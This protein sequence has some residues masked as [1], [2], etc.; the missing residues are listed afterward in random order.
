MSFHIGS[1]TKTFTAT[2]ILMLVDRGM[3]KLDT[4]VDTI[5]PGALPNGDKITVRHLL[6][7]RSG[8]SDYPAAEIFKQTI[9]R[10]PLHVWTFPELA[11]LVQV[12]DEP[13]ETFAYR[14]INFVTLGAI[15]E[16]LTGRSRADFVAHE[17]CEPLGL[18]HTFVPAD[19]KMPVNS[20][21]GYLPPDT[22]GEL[23][24]DAGESV[25]PSWGGAAGDM[26]STAADLV[27]WLKALSEGTLLSAERRQDMFAM[28]GDFLHGR[29]GGYGQGVLMFSGAVGHGGDYSGIYTS[30]LFEYQNHYMAVL[31]N[32]QKQEDGGDATALFLNWPSAFI[33]LP[34]TRHGVL[35][36]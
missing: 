16:K 4:T 13:D 25:D 11:R 1:V 19:Q 2:A 20:A 7:M 12:E 33:R 3:L 34:K 30:A 31:V 21:H 17:I 6:M 24:E 18:T 15:L 32:G 36:N 26:I 27:K 5:L 9:E 14:N 35:D 23:P 28:R 8:L 10:N 29:F 22:A